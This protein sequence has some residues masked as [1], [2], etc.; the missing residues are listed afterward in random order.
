MFQDILVNLCFPLSAARHAEIHSMLQ[1]AFRLDAERSPARG[2]FS[3]NP[4]AFVREYAFL[5][6]EEFSSDALISHKP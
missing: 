4:A 6:L 1:E 3:I 5:D 2:L